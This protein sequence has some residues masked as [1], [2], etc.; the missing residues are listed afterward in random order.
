MKPSSTQ[1]TTQLRL[2][3]ETDESQIWGTL[4]P[5]QQRHLTDHLARLWLQ[6]VIAKQT[7]IQPN[8]TSSASSSQQS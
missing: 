5:S 6:F 3:L 2:A 4:E 8:A 7:A 1:P